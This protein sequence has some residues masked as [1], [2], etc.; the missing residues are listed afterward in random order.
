VLTYFV[1]AFAISWGGMLVVIGGPGALPA[2]P[3]QLER[4][5]PFVWAAYVAGPT[6]ASVL[7][8]GLVSGRA[9]LSELLSRMMRWRVGAPWYGIA[10]HGRGNDGTKAKDACMLQLTGLAAHPRVSRAPVRWLQVRRL[11]AVLLGGV[12]S[13]DA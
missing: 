13:D 2:P 9:G 11:S 12:R 4:L 8:T 3:D 1:L 6:V 10:L 5:K 7:L